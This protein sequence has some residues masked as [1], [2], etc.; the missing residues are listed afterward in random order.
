MDNLLIFFFFLSGLQKLDFGR[1]SLLLPGRAKDL[2][3]PR[4][5][6]MT[7]PFHCLLIVV[8][9]R[10]SESVARPEVEWG[11]SLD[12]RLPKLCGLIVQ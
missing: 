8:S 12:N 10:R 6:G 5:F 9:E 3:A 4:Y 11:A 7:I 1:C 2:S